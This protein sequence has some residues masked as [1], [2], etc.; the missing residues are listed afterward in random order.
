MANQQD[1]SK[2]HTKFKRSHPPLKRYRAPQIQ[3]LSVA[4]TAGGTVS[5]PKEN[6]HFTNLSLN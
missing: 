2:T 3:K 6:G 4:S 1:T 5:D